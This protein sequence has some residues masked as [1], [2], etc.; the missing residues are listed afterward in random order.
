MADFKISR[1]HQHIAFT[2]SVVEY[3]VRPENYVSRPVRDESTGAYDLLIGPRDG[4]PMELPTAMGD[5]VHNLNSA[6]DYIWSGFARAANPAV[7]SKV[8]F[9]RHEELPNLADML[10]KSPVVRAFPE[11]ESLVI[12]N[13]R[14][15]RAGDGEIWSLNKL[16]IIDKHRLLLPTLSIA[17]LGKF[18]ATAADGAVI[19]LSYASIKTAGPSLK[20]GFSAPFKLNED[21]EIEVDVVFGESEPFATEPVMQVLERLHKKSLEILKVFSVQYY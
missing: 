15:Y 14:P 17:K 16:D 12:Q 5:V 3:L 21:A 20:L 19:N 1:A 13:V 2:K 7:T 18:V 6:L 4:F 8:T 11:L 9:P 10:S